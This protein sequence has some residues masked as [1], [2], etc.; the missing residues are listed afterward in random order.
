MNLAYVPCS[1][2]FQMTLFSSFI[3]TLN[4]ILSWSLQVMYYISFAVLVTTY[5]S[6]LFLMK[7]HRL[8]I[9]FYTIA[10]LVSLVSGNDNDDFEFCQVSGSTLP[11]LIYGSFPYPGCFDFCGLRC[12]NNPYSANHHFGT[13]R[14]LLLILSGLEE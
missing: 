8:I 1:C 7:M 11:R 3:W 14:R 2:R 13:V 4:W 6:M 10:L 12:W 9:R 5:G